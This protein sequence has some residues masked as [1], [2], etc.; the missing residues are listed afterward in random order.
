M[1]RTAPAPGLGSPSLPGSATAT[2]SCMLSTTGRR[3]QLGVQWAPPH[4]HHHP[5]PLRELQGRVCVGGCR[6]VANSS[7]PGVV[8]W[9]TLFPPHCDD[10]LLTVQPD[11][12]RSFHP[13][14]TLGMS[15]RACV[16]LLRGT[17]TPKLT[18]VAVVWYVAAGGHAK[19]LP[20]C[21]RVSTCLRG[22]HVPG[23]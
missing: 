9:R 12:W 2:S 18:I 17:V 4:S 14:I 22:W 3:S 5:S 1:H 15:T 10:H 13:C 21:W 7:A 19:A 8:V 6:G 11:R 23:W 16:C 20:D